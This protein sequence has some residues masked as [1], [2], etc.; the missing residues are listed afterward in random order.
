MSQSSDEFQARDERNHFEIPSC[1]AI[2]CTTVLRNLIANASSPTGCRWRSAS[3]AELRI[4]VVDCREN[5]ESPKIHVDGASS[6]PQLRA[7]EFQIR[8]LGIYKSKEMAKQNP[9]DKTQFGLS[10]IHDG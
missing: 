2:P 3:A 1:L 9:K 10:H 4:T 5:I 8:S 7:S 6:Q